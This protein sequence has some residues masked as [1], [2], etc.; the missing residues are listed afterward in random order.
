MKT[1]KLNFLTTVIFFCAGIVIIPS[2]T[3]LYGMDKNTS[4]ALQYTNKFP[5]LANPYQKQQQNAYAPINKPII[6]QVARILT[7]NCE[8]KSL[9]VD[10]ETIKQF[11]T[12]KNM[13]ADCQAIPDY[14][15]INSIDLPLN[16]RAVDTL[17]QGMNGHIPFDKLTGSEVK[18]LFN[19]ADYLEAPYK[20]RKV[21]AD[22]YEQKV[23]K[24]LEENINH[25]H[26]TLL[27]THKNQDSS[28]L[29]NLHAQHIAPREEELKRMR[30]KLSGQKRSVNTMLLE[31][32]FPLTIEGI[33]L[34]NQM[35]KSLDGIEKL[36][37][38][39]VKFI[40]LRNNKLK[41]LRLAL[42]KKHFPNIIAL[43]A[44][45][46]KIEKLKTSDVDALCDNLHLDLS[47]NNLKHIEPCSRWNAPENV[48]IDLNNYGLDVHQ[49]NLTTDALESLNDTLSPSLYQRKKTDM[50][51]AIRTAS[52]RYNNAISY[53][54]QAGV[55]A[56]PGIFMGLCRESF[57]N[58]IIHLAGSYV[59]DEPLTAIYSRLPQALRSSGMAMLFH[60]LSTCGYTKLYA[61]LG[62]L[63]NY[64]PYLYANKPLAYKALKTAL[65][66]VE[67]CYRLELKMLE[68]PKIVLGAAVT[69]YGIG[70]GLH[71]ASQ[72]VTKPFKPSTIK[73]ENGK[74]T[75]T[76]KNSMDA[77]D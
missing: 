36:T 4:M 57:Y 55:A 71:L 8:G 24:P 67:L 29:A 12:L 32:N 28:Y 48:H 49:N 60:G 53:V 11:K 9:S 41:E 68:N 62:S 56:L 59:I 70:Q 23:L 75:S 34:S 66:P 20:T 15:T 45:H 50:A 26:N 18:N 52:Q 40:S 1:K 25:D 31:N 39:Q 73:S 46:N 76:T 47:D 27:R 33:N 19:A 17:L 6:K 30:V 35:L 65:I 77:L 74:A 61:G 42:I 13:L 51:Q 5:I 64:A 44:S 69:A 54:G 72:R 10:K 22:L 2:L 38:K 58:P 16:G 37:S 14:T 21:L 43:Q 7:L 63:Y 3:S